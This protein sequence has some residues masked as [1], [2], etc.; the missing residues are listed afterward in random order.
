MS[1]QANSKTQ[2]SVNGK[3]RLLKPRG[4]HWRIVGAEGK[5]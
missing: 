4:E 3:G 1:V 5:D 2:R